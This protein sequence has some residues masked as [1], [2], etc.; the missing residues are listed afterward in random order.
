MGIG[1]ITW[2]KGGGEACTKS[3]FAVGWFSFVL[4]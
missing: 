4:P 1:S 2:S 3:I